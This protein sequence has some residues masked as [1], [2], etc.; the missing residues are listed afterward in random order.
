VRTRSCD[1]CGISAIGVARAT[2]P[3]DLRSD[4]Q[5]RIGALLV[6]VAGCLL[7]AATFL[8]WTAFAAQYVDGGDGT[9]SFSGWDLITDCASRTF[10]GQ[11]VFQ[12][13]QP[14]A[15]FVPERV[16]AGDWALVASASFVIIGVTLLAVRSRGRQSGVL[17][18]VGWVVALAA[19]ACGI[20]MIVLFVDVHNAPDVRSIESGAAIAA[21]CPVVALVGLAV[22]QTARA[23]TRSVTL[24]Y[25]GGESIV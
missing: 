6:V 5:A 11:C 19:L 24:G 10:P 3:L 23:R 13:Q 22:A 16:V 21:T 4:S 2:R 17:I 8:P 7:F 18:A 20:A 15:E 9:R 25:S 12:D 1:H 14:S